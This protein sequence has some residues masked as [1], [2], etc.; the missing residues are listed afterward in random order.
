MQTEELVSLFR[1]ACCAATSMHSVALFVE[2]FAHKIVVGSLILK[3]ANEAGVAVELDWRS[4]RRGHGRVVEEYHQYVTDLI[5]QKDR[6]S[7]LL[8]V[9]TDANCK[10]LAERL[11]E[12]DAGRVPVPVVL[13][14]PDPHVERWLLLDGAAFKK[15]L[16]RGCDKPDLKCSRNRYKDQLLKEIREAGITPSLGGIEYGEDLVREMDIDR[17]CVETRHWAGS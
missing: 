15:V 7:D 14:I 8:V 3:L 2:D 9:A 12:F 11:K 5:H 1:S 10:G 16:G 17:A 13:A 4:A 6:S